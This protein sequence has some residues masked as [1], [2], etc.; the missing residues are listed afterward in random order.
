VG[1]PVCGGVVRC[2]LVATDLDVC[3]ADL[4][5]EFDRMPMPTRMQKTVKIL[6]GQ[7]VITRSGSAMLDVVS[8]ARLS[9]LVD[10][11]PHRLFERGLGSTAPAQSLNRMRLP[12][13]QRPQAQVVPVPDDAH[14][15]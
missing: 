9:C 4:S 14:S 3:E 13:S 10:R 8:V 7:P 12:V 2:F 6:I 5:N 15:R 11:L 1:F